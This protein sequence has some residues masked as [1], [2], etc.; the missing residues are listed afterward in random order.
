MMRGSARFVSALLFLCLGVN[1]TLPPLPEWNEE[2]QVRLKKGELI[3]GRALLTLEGDP[4]PKVN[5]EDPIA[6]P[7]EPRAVEVPEPIV[8]VPARPELDPIPVSSDRTEIHQKLLERYFN[9]RPEPG[10]I[11]P[12]HLLSMQESEDTRYAFREHSA[13]SSLPIYFFLFDA[14]Q[15]VPEACSP[16]FVYDRLF[17]ADGQPVVIIYYFMGEPSRTQFFLGG[18]VGDDVPEWQ[19]R[20]LLVNASHTAAEKTDIFDQLDDFVGQ[21]SMRLFWV[22]KM[23]E[24]LVNKALPQEVK[25]E[26]QKKDQVD[27]GK[28]FGALS[29][30]GVN[31]APYILVLVSGVVG[32][33]SC[34]ALGFFWMRNRRYIFPVSD[35]GK[36]RLGAPRGVSSGGVLSF[37]NMDQPPSEQTAQ[38]EQDLL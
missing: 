33:I 9:S 36:G 22:E 26:N 20:E 17:A 27:Y 19:L 18:A 29:S 3:V 21:L 14:H 2:D 8:P 37:R 4:K 28:W 34:A 1:A 23:L 15:K 38:F 6:E 13:E 24:E 16:Q 7:E 30:L 10:L 25:Q 5:P 11:D 12:Q 35:G 31:V 32:I